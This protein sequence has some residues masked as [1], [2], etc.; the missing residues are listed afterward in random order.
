MQSLSD[1][2]GTRAWTGKAKQRGT[3]RNKS[4]T[5]RFTKH[6]NL[7]KTLACDNVLLSNWIYMLITVQYHRR[8]HECMICITHRNW[9]AYG[10]TV[11][12]HVPSGRAFRCQVLLGQVAIQLSWWI[13]R[14]NM[15]APFILCILGVD[16]SMIAVETCH[17]FEAVTKQSVV[18][19][20]GYPMSLRSTHE[21][22]QRGPSAPQKS[23]SK[24][25]VLNGGPTRSCLLY[26]RC[27]LQGSFSTIN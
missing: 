13:D 6:I 25:M 21:Y 5:G 10:L 18:L 1:L 7:R 19:K 27:F 20:H 9:L 24:M 11:M 4:P 14:H 16:P 17:T 22:F 26:L 23:T 15:T 8:S 3:A 12:R 2:V